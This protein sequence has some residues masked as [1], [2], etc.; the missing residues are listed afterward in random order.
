ML[1]PLSPYKEHLCRRDLRG[2]QTLIPISA[3]DG[4]SKVPLLTA[5]YTCLAVVLPS[6][7]GQTSGT[8]SKSIED[9]VQTK[10]TIPDNDFLTL[11]LT[12]KLADIVTIYG[13]LTCTIAD[14]RD[15]KWSSLE[16]L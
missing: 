4:H 15:L 13:R 11:D 6:Q 14:P 9:I 2:E 5:L 12:K 10:L 1:D 8:W 16:L 3:H 7:A